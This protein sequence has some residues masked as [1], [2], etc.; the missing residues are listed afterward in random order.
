MKNSKNADKQV[1]EIAF[2]K[3]PASPNLNYCQVRGGQIEI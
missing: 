3:V 1:Q 2:A